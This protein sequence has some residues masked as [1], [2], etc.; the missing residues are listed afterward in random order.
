M[1]PREQNVFIKSDGWSA[2]S[3]K[4]MALE[5]KC[6]LTHL[7]HYPVQMPCSDLSILPPSLVFLS[8]LLFVFIDIADFFLECIL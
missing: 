3:L 6:F 7:Y 4:F 1:H 2:Q 5:I 8:S